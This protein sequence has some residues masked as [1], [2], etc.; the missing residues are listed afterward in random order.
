VNLWLVAQGAWVATLARKAHNR[1]PAALGAGSDR[2]LARS[3][4]D[5]FGI[6]ACPQASHRVAFAALP[7]RSVG[8][9]RKEDRFHDELTRLWRIPPLIIDLCRRRNF[10]VGVVHAATSPAQY[11]RRPVR[12]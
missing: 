2:S 10:S 9:A 12:P 5:Y 7:N 8:Q 11:L 4:K 1:T 3:D 6:G